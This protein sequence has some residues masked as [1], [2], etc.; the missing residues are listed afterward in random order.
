MHVIISVTGYH[1]ADDGTPVE[2]VVTGRAGNGTEQQVGRFGVTPDVAYHVNDAA[3]AMRFSFRIPP[4][5]ISSE[6]VEFSVHI[7]PVRGTGSGA[8]LQIGDAEIR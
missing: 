4:A 8:S 5:L 3:D 6:P 2:M 1:P 7:V